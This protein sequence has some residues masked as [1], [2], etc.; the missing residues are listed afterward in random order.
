MTFLET[1]LGE[2][3][4]IF[5]REGIEANSDA[6]LIRKLDIRQSTFHELF[7]GREDMVKQAILFDIEVENRRQMDLLSKASNPVEGVMTLLLDGIKVIKQVNPVY[8]GDL[9]KYPEAWHMSMQNVIDNNRHINAEILN[10][11]I[12]QGYF[13]K[14]LNLQLVTKIIIEQ[15]F[16][17]LNPV[18]FPPDKYDLSDVFRSVYLYYVR[19]ICT[20][21]GGKLAEEYFA[22]NKI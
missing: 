22:N 15:F 1:I 20:E 14:D 12:L 16:M 19:G 17:I 3:L 21:M 5:K 18:S 11:G 9:Q 13:R 10:R 4:Q 8:I 2:L 7:S 6:D